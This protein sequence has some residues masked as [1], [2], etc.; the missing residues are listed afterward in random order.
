MYLISYVL[1]WYTVFFEYS[2]PLDTAVTLMPTDQDSRFAFRVCCGIL[3][4]NINIP[5]YVWA[6]QYPSSLLNYLSWNSF[7]L[8]TDIKL[9]KK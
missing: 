9:K 3:L 2:L 5:Q 7:I 8:K 4:W 1:H 6:E